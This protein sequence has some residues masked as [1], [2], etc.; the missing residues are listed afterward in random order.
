LQ[1]R[2]RANTAF[3]SIQLRL[4]F[5][6]FILFGFQNVAAMNTLCSIRAAMK[7]VAQLEDSCTDNIVDK[8]I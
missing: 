6:I 8:K 2:Y 1:T 4:N 5:S 3:W 7:F